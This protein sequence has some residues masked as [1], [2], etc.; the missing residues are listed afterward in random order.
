M[1]RKKL[2]S[3][4]TLVHALAGATGA[5][6]ATTVFYPLDT[7]RSRLQVEDS[8]KARNTLS[9]IKELVD[10]EGIETLYRGIYPVLSSLCCSNFVYF[11]TFHGLRRIVIS[12]NSTHNVVRDLSV[13]AIA[14]VINVVLT[15]PLWTANS[16]I[17]LQGAK[18]SEAD[19]IQFRENLKYKGLLDAVVKIYNQEGWQSLWSGLG[20]SLMLVSMPALQFTIYEA[21]KLELFKVTSQKELSSTMYFVASAISKGISTTLTYPLQLVQAKFRSGSR[22]VKKLNTLQAL[23]DI[24]RSN[25]AKGLFKGLEAK[26][27]QTVLTASL[28]F[29]CYEKIVSFVFHIMRIKRYY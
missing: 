17:K 16:R 21:L 4:E 13:A 19:K 14:G 26:L 27:L 9:V 7:V 29:L 23:L 11:Y 1:S 6:V 10:E 5:V 8:R 3:Y 12:G 25:G 18:F 28:M 24:I 22:N 20:P 15:T 2:F